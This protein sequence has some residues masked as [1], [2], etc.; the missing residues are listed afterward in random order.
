MWEYIA[1]WV[2]TIIVGIALAPKNKVP[3]QAPGELGGI[4]TAEAGKTIPV[5]FGTRII[6][7]PNV[8]WWG[9]LGIVPITKKGGKK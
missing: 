6:Q 2:V 4:A 5:V 7:Q 8:V 1:L 3:T 9:D